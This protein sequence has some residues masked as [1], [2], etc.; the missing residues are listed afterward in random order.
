MTTVKKLLTAED[1]LALPD[2][3]MRQELVRGELIEMPPP[4]L[5][6]GLVAGN[7]YRFFDAFVRQAEL[8]LVTTFEIGIYLEQDPD[9]VRAPDVSLIARHRIPES[10]PPSGYV[11]GLVPDLVVE[12]ISPGYRSRAA[13]DARVD[14]WLNAGVRLVLVAHIANREIVSHHDDG[15]V[16]RFGIDDTLT[17]EP[18]LPGFSCPVADIFTC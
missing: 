15:T 9:T 12:V 17:C 4:G 14:M 13:V 11:F 2:N 16:Q 3:G 5:M 1:L 8:D 10:M 6:H 18:V 7:F